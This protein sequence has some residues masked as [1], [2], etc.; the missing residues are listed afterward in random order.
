VAGIGHFDNAMQPIT[1]DIEEH[2][3]A[4]FTGIN[5]VLDK[6]DQRLFQAFTMAHHL[7]RCLA[8]QH[9]R[10]HCT[11]P[12]GNAAGKLGQVNRR[13]V[14]HLPRTISPKPGQQRIEFV[15]RIAQGKQHIGAERR[16]IRVLFSIGCKQR[17]L[18]DQVLDIVHHKRDAAVELIK[19]AGVHQGLL[20]GLFG[21]I[22]GELLTRDAQQIEIFPV[23]L[24]FDPRPGQHNCTH[25]AIEMEQRHQRPCVFGLQQPCRHLRQFPVMIDTPA[26]LIE[27]NHQIMLFDQAG[28]PIICRHRRDRNCGPVPA[29]G[30]FQSGFFAGHQQ[31]PCRAFG[32]VGQCLDGTFVQTGID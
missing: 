21:Q 3:C 10:V 22:T 18:A 25:Q 9:H 4:R 15:G 5:R 29:R 26:R 16:I 27:G 11:E 24:A 13:E 8:G 19:P 30:Q 17:K 14:M 6:V 31:Q 7:H 32:D 2:R 20:P 12:L 1:S 23:K 28:K